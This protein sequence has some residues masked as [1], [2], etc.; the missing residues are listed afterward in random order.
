MANSSVSLEFKAGITENVAGN[1]EDSYMRLSRSRDLT[2]G[3]VKRGNFGM[4]AF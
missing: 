2:L 3:G 4:F 1:R